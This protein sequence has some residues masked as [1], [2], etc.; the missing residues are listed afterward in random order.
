ML[1]TGPYPWH[2]KQR[3]QSRTGHLSNADSKKLLDELQHE[4]LQHVILAH[5]SE[6]NNTPQK[7]F[8]EVTRALTRCKARL[9]VADQYTSGPV[10]YLR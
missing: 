5:L 8:N 1:E 9:T 6:I 2:L 7:A 10:I 3:I 4:K